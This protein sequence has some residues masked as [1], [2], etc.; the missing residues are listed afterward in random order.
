MYKIFGI[1]A[2]T[3]FILGASEY[4]HA[5]TWETQPALEIGTDEQQPM[6]I[7]IAKAKVRQS[8]RDLG[9]SHYGLSITHIGQGFVTIQGYGGVTGCD[10]CWIAVAQATCGFW[11]Y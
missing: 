6:A 9:G 4:S 7:E 2:A 1:I 3:I 10:T 5:R 11:I 8:C